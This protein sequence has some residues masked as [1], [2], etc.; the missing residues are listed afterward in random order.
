MRCLLIEDYLPLRTSIREW[1]WDAGFVVD[2]SGTG[3]VG[4]WH[5]S[6]YAYDVIVL[7]LML[8]E[9]DGLT[10]LRKLR[11]LHDKTPVIIISAKDAVSQRIEGLDA[12]ADDYLV[13]PFDLA[14]LVA[15]VRVLVRRKFA[16]EKSEFTIG[17]LTIN[18][19]KKLVT[20]SGKPIPL[21]PLEFKLLE[22]LAHRQG[23]TVSRADIQAHIYH[24]HGDSGS[25]KIDV[26]LTYL[27]KKLTAHG[28]PD[29]ITT[30]RGHGFVIGAAQE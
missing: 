2:E 30:R 25:N 29:L 28:L 19:A 22:Y 26:C 23:E 20:F 5:A 9:I 18:S 1:L 8:P 3:D 17:D 12:G 16:L 7:D 13:K 11:D 14:E 6:N 21:T 10:I 15:R 4:L 27:R 24:D